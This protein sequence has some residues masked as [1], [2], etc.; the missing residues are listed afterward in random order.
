M[1]GDYRV[2]PGHPPLMRMA[3]ALALL[4]ARVA[5]VDT[6][7]IDRTS[8]ERWMPDVQRG[9]G[10]RFLYLDNDADQVLYRARFVSVLVGVLLGALIF[11]WSRDWLGP[12][13]ALIAVALFALEPNLA[14]H[15]SLVTTDGGLAC[16]V[17]GTVYFLWRVTRRASAANI[18]GF[19]LFFVLA[20]TTKFSAMLLAPLVVIL[21]GAA[22]FRD[23]SVAIGRAVGI[24]AVLGVCTWTGVWAVYG[25]RYAP[26]SNQSWLFRYQAE[27]FVAEAAPATAAV[28]TWIDERRLLPN[29]FSQGLLI[30]QVFAQGRRAFIAGEYG[31]DG[32]W[33]F[34]PLAILIKTPIALLLLS[35]GAFLPRTLLRGDDRQTAVFLLAPIAVFL[36]TAIVSNINIGLR[37]VLMIYPFLIMA[38]AYGARAALNQGSRWARPALGALGVALL[39]EFGRAYPHPLAFFNSLVGGPARGAQYLVDSN[40]DWGQDLKGLKGWMDSNGVP[41]INLAYFGSADPRYYGIRG[42]YLPGSPGFLPKD[43]MGA[44]RLPGYVAVS[45]TIQSGVYVEEPDRSFYKPLQAHAPVASIGYTINVYRVESRWW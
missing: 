13:P 7:I 30:T 4:T 40:L 14:A 25:F 10:H 18:A 9:L 32:W 41:E 26:S 17:F 44:P 11:F 8:A 38:A 20:V 35:A 33:Y 16:F 45:A 12:T 31:T 1:L 6:S 28:V 24:L 15:F 21:L 27:P 19:I 37:H 42:V 23:R 2:D 22:V 34:F 43:M 39:F 29:A 5:R 36:G 3:A